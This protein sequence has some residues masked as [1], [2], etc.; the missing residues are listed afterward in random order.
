MRHEVVR[1]PPSHCQYSIIELIWA[2]FK[3]SVTEKNSTFKIADVVALL[4]KEID[5]VTTNDLAKCGKHC[6]K[7]QEEDLY[8]A[9]MRNEIIRTNNFNY[10]SKRQQF[11]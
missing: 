8:K 7:H 1:I 3:R 10:L 2:Q 4:N 9:R 5:V 11:E 6:A